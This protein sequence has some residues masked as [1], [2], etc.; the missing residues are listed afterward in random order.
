[1]MAPTP[2]VLDPLESLLQPSRAGE[3]RVGL[4]VPSSGVLGLNGPA[5]LAAATLA[6]EEAMRTDAARGHELVLV[7]LDAG[8]DPVTVASLVGLHLRAGSI[9]VVCGFHTS[10]VHRA[11][12]AVTAGVVP[13]LFTPPHEGGARREGVVL[14]GAGPHQQNAVVAARLARER[15]LRRWALV[16]N[17]YI[18]PRSVHRAAG[19]MLARAGAEVVHSCLVPFHE[20]RAAQLVEELK[21]SRAQAVLLSL[22]GR[23]LVTFNRVFAASPLSGNVIRVSGSLDETGLLE[24]DGDDTGELYAAMPWFA[25]DEDDGFGER[26]AARFGPM[27]PPL[28][29]YARGCYDG[30][31]LIAWLAGSGNLRADRVLA[32]SS[33][34]PVV[35]REVG[36]R[37]ARAQGIDLVAM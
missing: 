7:P 10:D 34:A 28:G 31:H 17:D 14:L 30:I 3:V 26:Y 18:W 35:R 21:R 6:V 9:D 16:G 11:V 13:Y 33:C 32:A 20:V 12:E 37:L 27:A 4:A 19:P 36:G 24:I 25:T 29:A 1:M 15:S 23:D 22:V 5:A 8:T 2:H